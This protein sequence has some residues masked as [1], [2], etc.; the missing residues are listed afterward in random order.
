MSGPGD[1]ST[2]ITG[3]GDIAD[4]VVGF[5]VRLYVCPVA[6]LSTDLAYSCSPCLVALSEHSFAHLHHRLDLFLQLLDIGADCKWG[7]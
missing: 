6:F 3:V 5:Y 4:D 2:D 1:L 7:H